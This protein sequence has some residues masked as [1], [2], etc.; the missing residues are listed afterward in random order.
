MSNFVYAASH[1]WRVVSDSLIARHF[2][3]KMPDG[4][5]VLWESDFRAGEEDR[6]PDDQSKHLWHGGHRPN[7]QDAHFATLC[8]VPLITF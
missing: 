5:K 4:V 2:A 1:G 8:P 3:S 6:T 7:E